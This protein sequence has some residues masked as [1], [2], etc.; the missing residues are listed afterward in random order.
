[1]WLFVELYKKYGWDDFSLTILCQCTDQEADQV[2][3]QAIKQHSTLSPNGYNLLPG[4]TNRKQ[5]PGRTLSEEHKEKLRKPKPI[6]TESHCKKISTHRVNFWKDHLPPFT[7][8]ELESL[9]WAMPTTKIAEKFQM[10]DN[11][12]ARWVR[13]WNL[14]KPPRGYWTGK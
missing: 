5:L 7:R 8:E 14:T 10:S 2:E 11:G 3:E 6:R 1:M 13:R 4:G 12:V 9:L